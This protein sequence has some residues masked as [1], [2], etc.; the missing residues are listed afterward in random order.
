[1]EPLR[2]KKRRS[3]RSTRRLPAKT[4]ATDVD[5]LRSPF[6][7]RAVA[8]LERLARCIALRTA[9]YSRSVAAGAFSQVLGTPVQGEPT[10]TRQTGDRSRDSSA[11][12][13]DRGCQSSVA[14]TQS[15]RRIDDARHR[16]LRAHG[17]PNAPNTPSAT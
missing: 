3:P 8:D 10:T 15:S 11:D 7:G 14:C 17:L 4:S 9:R 16:D 2:W 5:C 12:R 6:L 13:T 1:M